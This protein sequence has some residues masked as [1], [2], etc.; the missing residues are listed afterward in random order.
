MDEDSTNTGGV[1]GRADSDTQE[2]M[3][4]ENFPGFP[5]DPQNDSVEAERTFDHVKSVV[6][7]GSPDSIAQ[8]S[9]RVPE[10]F[11]KNVQHM[12]N[13]TGKCL[14]RKIIHFN[15]TVST[16]YLDGLALRNFGKAYGATTSEFPHHCISFV[17]QC[18]DFTAVRTENDVDIDALGLKTVDFVTFVLMMEDAERENRLFDLK[19]GVKAREHIGGMDVDM[20]DGH[21]DDPFKTPRK[22]SFSKVKDGKKTGSAGRGSASTKRKRPS[23]SR[24]SRV[25]S[26]KV[27]KSRKGE[28]IPSIV[29]CRGGYRDVV[30]YWLLTL[31]R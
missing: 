21:P 7:S 30:V 8:L 24:R 28:C 18:G 29:P 19:T 13:G 25:S 6:N 26:D 27:Q 17:V 11:V 20:M 1:R 12:V 10:D 14:Q 22:E 9:R 15:G 31:P 23:T 2:T 3:Q 16:P 4:F 5:A